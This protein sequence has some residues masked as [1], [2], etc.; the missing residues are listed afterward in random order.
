MSWQELVWTY[1]DR[2]DPQHPLTGAMHWWVPLVWMVVGYCAY[3]VLGLVLRLV[4]RVLELIPERSPR[5][6]T[7]PPRSRRDRKYERRIAEIAE[8][9]ARLDRQG[10]ELR[11]ERDERGWPLV[12]APEALDEE[13]RWRIFERDNF[14]CV[15]CGSRRRLTVD[16]IYPRS[17][18]GTNAESNLRTLCRSCNSRKGARV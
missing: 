6:Y 8:V 1:T 17:R 10:N 15:E 11:R 4:G 12:V 7:P 5:P 18:G 2:S 9:R 3:L 14:T 13:L 16:H